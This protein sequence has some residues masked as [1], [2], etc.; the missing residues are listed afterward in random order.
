MSVYVKN[1]DTVDQVIRGRTVSPNAY[2]L[3]PEFER[4]AWAADQDLFNK[5]ST[6]LI[7]FAKSSDGLNDIDD[8]AEQWSFL[9]NLLPSQSVVV[10]TVPPTYLPN[11]IQIDHSSTKVDLPRSSESY[12]SIYTYSGSG[13]L[14]SF[15]MDF[16][17]DNVLIKLTVDSNVIFE[18]DCDFLDDISNSDDDASSNGL[19]WLGFDA[20]EN[21]ILFRP[22]YPIKFTTEVKI[23]AK[24]NSSSSGRDM[25]GYLVDIIKES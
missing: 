1:L 8:Y 9:N 3:V 7:K 17:S 22:T 25:T 16:N 4:S 20:S 2:F 5:V 21:R 23:E 10:E 13:Q 6:D 12:A 24:A 15:T 18:I 19:G 11:Q 14:S